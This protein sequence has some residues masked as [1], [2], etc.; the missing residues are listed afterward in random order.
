VLAMSNAIH[1]RVHNVYVTDTGSW[2]LIGPMSGTPLVVN[3]SLIALVDSST[4]QVT[5]RVH[6]RATRILIG[7][8]ATVDG[9]G[10]GHAQNTAP[11][12]CEAATNK[13]ES[14]YQAGMGGSHAG[15]AL[16]K[17]AHVLCCSRW[18]VSP[19]ATT[20]HIH[21]RMCG[22]GHACLSMVCVLG[23]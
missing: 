10:R 19:R 20:K 3:A 13:V 15:T 16:G 22:D 17:V 4:A 18:I 11:P 7:P 9:V 8:G 5:G 12:G 6:W 2:N 1:A 23:P 21:A 14:L